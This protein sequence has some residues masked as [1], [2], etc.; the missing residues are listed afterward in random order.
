MPAFPF[1]MR[2][3]LEWRRTELGLEE[4]KLRQI[5]ARVQELDL[6][7]KR[8]DLTR[9]RAEE[10]VRQSRSAEAADLWALAAYRRRVL[11]ELQV[12][13]EQ[14]R[15]AEQEMTFQR[16]KVAAADRQCR[17]LEKL[18]ERQCA[19]WQAQSLREQETL[20]GESFLAAWNRRRDGF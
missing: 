7:A 15:R 9:V 18:E 10:T 14:K 17:L 11:S 3:V 12:L 2:R 5:A 4:N 16:E 13:G 6:T 20:A 8:L 19:Q 1:R